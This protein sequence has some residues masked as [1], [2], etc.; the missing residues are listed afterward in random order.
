[1]QDFY[2]TWQRLQAVY[3]VQGLLDFPAFAERLQL[4]L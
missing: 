1:M 3:L 2:R 4:D